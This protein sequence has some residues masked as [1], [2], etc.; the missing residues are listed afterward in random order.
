LPIDELDVDG[1]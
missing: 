1:D